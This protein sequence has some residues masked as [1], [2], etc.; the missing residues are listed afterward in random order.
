[1]N[2]NP[3]KRLGLN[4]YHFEND[5]GLADS[6]KSSLALKKKIEMIPSPP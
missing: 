2:I 5:F 1:V 6:L 3:G 4:S